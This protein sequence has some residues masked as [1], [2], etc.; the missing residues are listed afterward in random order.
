MQ[1]WR[2]TQQTGALQT[3]VSHLDGLRGLA[4]LL[5]IGFHAYA[6]WGNALPYRTT[7]ANVPLFSIGR[8][9]VQLFFLISGF[10]IFWTLD[11][12]ANL[13]TFL[14][15]RLLRLAPAMVLASALIY[16]TAPL[17]SER[18]GGI[19]QPIDLL[20]GLTFMDPT[21]WSRLLGREVQ[22]LGGGFWTLYIEFKFYV[23]AGLIYFGLGRKQLAPC[24]LGLFGFSTLISIS[25]ITPN[26][27]I[28]EALGEIAINLSL[29]SFGWFA[30]GAY[31]YLYHQTKE[32]YLMIALLA[33]L[34]S[35]RLLGKG[36]D[37]NAALVL[38]AVFAVS[39]RSA[40]VQRLISNPLLLFFGFISYP[41]YLIHESAMVAITAK[42]GRLAPAPDVIMFFY[43]W[44]AIAG[45]SLLAFAIAR[46]YEPWA[47][48]R[49]E[50]VLGWPRRSPT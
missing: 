42:L 32:A 27:P 6:R 21:W 47:R 20:P 31:F 23:I 1:P 46:H 11:K 17:L 15:K 24:L 35:A 43:P 38:A 2:P 48:R 22:Q 13:Q 5:V 50:A 30:A 26:G 14:G 40:K 29:G 12:T 4:I 25:A 3:R 9:G 45:L 10:V 19:P 36:F 44:L 28:R 33:A 16:A 7:F 41:L 37:A 34:L 8:R 18:P 49:I 39:L